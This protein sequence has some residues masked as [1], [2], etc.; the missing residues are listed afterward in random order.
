MFSQLHSQ[1]TPAL[2]TL[3]HRRTADVH[4][5]AVVYSEWNAEITHA[6]RDGAVTTLL[7]C[8]LERQ[9]IETF[10]VPGAFE[11][12]YTATLLSEATQ[13]YDAIIIIGCVIRGE[14]SHYDL[15]CN[16][17]T[18]GATELNLRGKAPVIFGLVTVENIE[19]ARARSGGA[20]G[21]K[22]S[23]CAIA[24]LQTIDIRAAIQG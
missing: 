2:Y 4:R 16:S 10:S 17:V 8:G 12:T 19:Q 5:I 9:Q 21:N 7:E 20:V 3:Q 6:L 15:I 18:E 14:T 11:L 1:Q 24:A 22:G 13:P 23:E